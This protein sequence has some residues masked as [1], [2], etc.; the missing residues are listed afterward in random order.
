MLNAV[1][2]GVYKERGQLTTRLPD[3]SEAEEKK[4]ESWYKPLGDFTLETYD[5]MMASI[6]EQTRIVLAQAGEH[7]IEQALS[8]MLD[9]ESALKLIESSY[10]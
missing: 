9:A 4:L 7:A 6:P 1:M 8:G 10:P 2:T 3:L 5:D